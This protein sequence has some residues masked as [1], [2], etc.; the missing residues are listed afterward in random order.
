MLITGATQWCRIYL[1]MVQPSG[2]RSFHRRSASPAHFYLRRS[3]Y[4]KEPPVPRTTVSNRYSWVD[5]MSQLAC[6]IVTCASSSCKRGLLG[7]SFTAGVCRAMVL[8]LHSLLHTTLPAKCPG[9]HPCGFGRLPA[10]SRPFPSCHDF[11][12][13]IRHQIYWTC[14]VVFHIGLFGLGGWTGW[15]ALFW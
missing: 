13:R 11:D 12:F 3:S 8:S 5:L 1:Q 10:P 9:E 4:R 7:S 14:V 15:P 6:E 2:H